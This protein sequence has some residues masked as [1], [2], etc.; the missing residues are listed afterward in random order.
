MKIFLPLAQWW[1]STLFTIPI[2]QCLESILVPFSVGQF[3][4][5]GLPNMFSAVGE[6]NR[7]ALP[8]NVSRPWSLASTAKGQF[9]LFF[10]GSGFS[11][12]ISRPPSS[13]I[14]AWLDGQRSMTPFIPESESEFSDMNS[15][16]AN[17]FALDVNTKWGNHELLVDISA[18]E[19]NPVIFDRVEVLGSYSPEIDYSMEDDVPST[20]VDNDNDLVT[21][22]GGSNTWKHQHDPFFVISTASVTSTPGAWVQIALTGTGIRVYG[23]IPVEGTVFSVELVTKYGSEYIRNVTTRTITRPGGEVPIYR[24]I[25]FAERGLAYANAYAYKLILISGTLMVDFIDRGKKAESN[26]G[27]IMVRVDGIAVPAD[28][29]DTRTIASVPLYDSFGPNPG[30]ILLSVTGVLVFLLPFGVAYCLCKRYRLRRP[31][32]GPGLGHRPRFGISVEKIERKQEDVVQPFHVHAGSTLP[33]PS[34]SEGSTIKGPFLRILLRQPPSSSSSPS[35]LHQTSYL[36]SD[37]ALTGS[38][39]SSAALSQSTDLQE[40]YESRLG[41]H[42]ELEDGEP[43]SLSH[44]DLARVFRRAEQLRFLDDDARNGDGE[45]EPQLEAL[46]RQLASRRQ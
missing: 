44:A 40:P 12:H 27:V 25:L 18:T 35:L 6:W 32:S 2:V 34:T 28:V 29:G 24:T 33:L 3:T 46:A 23:A 7:F 17:M 10:R 4:V 41:D 5:G 43:M 16:L 14:S 37:S 30:V 1:I 38:A 15:G 36:H 26:V 13:S 22:S 31:G 9:I 39:S 19:D 8:A 42:Y 21:Y 11:L 45:L 20:F